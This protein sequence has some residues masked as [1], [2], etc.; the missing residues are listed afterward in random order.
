MI[1]SLSTSPISNNENDDNQ[2]TNSF[3]SANDFEHQIFG[4][5]LGRNPNSDSFYQ[6]LNKLEKTHDI[7]GLGSKLNGGN[8]SQFLDGLDESFNTLLDGMVLWNL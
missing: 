5:T 4:G 8:G 6:K 3:E 1:K 2:S 7:Y